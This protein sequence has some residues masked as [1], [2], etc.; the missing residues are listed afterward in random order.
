MINERLDVARVT[1]AGALEKFKI[2]T[3]LQVRAKSSHL[4]DVGSGSGGFLYLVRSHFERVTGIEVSPDCVKFSRQQL[5]LE[6]YSDLPEE[7]C[8]SVATFWHS[9]EHFQIEDLRALWTR[10]ARVG[11][12]DFRLLVSVPNGSSWVHRI[13]GARDPYYDPEGHHQEFSAASLELL[14]NQ[15]G[16]QRVA[17][18]PGLYYNVFGWHQALLNL[19][20][21][22]NALYS[23]LKRGQDVSRAAVAGSVLLSPF[24]LPFSCA[25]AMIDQLFWRSGAVLTLSF[26]P[27][28]QT[29]TNVD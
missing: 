2:R 25:G 26:R 20:F 27:A 8:P 17:A 14:A 22:R 6:I 15:V 19:F 4:L 18:H 21:P 23:F 9:A 5:R 29:D 7:L 13:F 28:R 1:R 24:L 3:L 16:L 12:A 10:L 11:G